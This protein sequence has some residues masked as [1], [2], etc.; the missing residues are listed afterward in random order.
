MYPGVL[1][2]RMR[3]RSSQS[4]NIFGLE[5]DLRTDWQPRA[6]VAPANPDGSPSC[7][8]YQ[9]PRVTTATTSEV[10]G[11]LGPLQ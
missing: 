11:L 5:R 2:R 1:R 8:G 3:S 9:R 7:P 6:I 4:A 10:T